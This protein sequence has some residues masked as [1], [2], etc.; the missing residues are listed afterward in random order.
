MWGRAGHEIIDWPEGTWRV[1]S[2]RNASGASYKQ[3]PVNLTHGLC[4]LEAALLTKVAV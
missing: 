4:G 3:L 1:R 2:G